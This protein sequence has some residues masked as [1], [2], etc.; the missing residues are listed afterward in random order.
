VGGGADRRRLVQAGLVP[1]TAGLVMVSAALLI[2]TTAT[3]CGT[4]A[5][6]PVAAALGATGVLE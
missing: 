6:T 1:V 4:A 2:R 3:R 5:V